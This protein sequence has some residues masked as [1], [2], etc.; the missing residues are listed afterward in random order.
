MEENFAAR[1]VTIRGE[2]TSETGIL[3]VTA[4]ITPE[5]VS[6]VRH[7]IMFLMSKITY[8][9]SHSLTKPENKLLPASTAAP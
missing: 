7:N 9:L 4:V 3:T 2:F 1:T 8:V 5:G 6:A